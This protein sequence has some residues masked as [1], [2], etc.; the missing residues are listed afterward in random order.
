MSVKRLMF[1]QKIYRISPQILFETMH[2]DTPS[3]IIIIKA[4]D[5]AHNWLETAV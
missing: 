3:V 5:N 2:F 1:L 4:E